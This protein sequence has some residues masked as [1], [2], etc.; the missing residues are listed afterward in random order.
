MDLDY[1]C[2]N[3]NY[4]GGLVPNR[5]LV[6]HFVIC[7]KWWAHSRLNAR[8]VK[9]VVLN[10]KREACVL[11]VVEHMD[12]EP[13]HKLGESVLG[14]LVPK[15]WLVSTPNIEYNPIIRGLEWDPESNSL[16]KGSQ[17]ISSELVES[18][19]M[20]DV[21]TPNLRNHDHRFEWTRAEFREWASHLAVQHD[22]QVSFAGVG[23]DGE[24]DENSPGF[25]TQIAVFARNVV[26][27]P[28][29][30]QS[31]SCSQHDGSNRVLSAAGIDESQI[32][33]EI[34]EGADSPL[35]ELWQW[36]LPAPLAAIL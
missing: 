11:K 12:P 25:A 14:K 13:L 2:A 29:F 34:R 15:L 8:A 22:Y 33:L 35:K 28:K 5:L 9:I 16:V 21:E 20:L 19:K 3:D 24:D 1:G 31:A 32:K 4:I 18:K 6:C 27:F 30:C 17:Q 7:K 10:L 36:T 26:V 23:G